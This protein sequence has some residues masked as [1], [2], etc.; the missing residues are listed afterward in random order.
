MLHVLGS[1]TDAQRPVREHSGRLSMWLTHRGRLMS[2]A[3]STRGA[4][5]GAAR[6]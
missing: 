6:W 3:G 4:C 2:S 1:V 5:V